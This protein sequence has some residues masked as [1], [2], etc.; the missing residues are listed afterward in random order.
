MKRITA[1]QR[2]AILELLERGVD[3][4]AIAQSLGV[5]KGQVAAVSAHLTM[6]TYGAAEITAARRRTRTAS[7]SSAEDERPKARSI[8]EA[9]AS[10][11]VLLGADVD[12]LEAR[13]WMPSPDEGT[14]NPHL[15]IVG[16]S[17]S[18]KTYAAQ[19][20]CAELVQQQIPAVIF[21]FGQGFSGTVV[22]EDFLRFAKALELNVGVDGVD[23]NPLQIFPS[24]IHGP[25]NVAQRIADTFAHVYPAIGVQQHAV[26]REAV[27]ET[28]R[29]AG[30]DQ[31]S[32][33]TWSE[34]APRLAQLRRSLERIASG[35]TSRGD[36]R[37]AATVLSHISTVFVF[38]VFRD[39][40][41]ELDWRKMFGAPA[42][43]YVLELKGLEQSLSRV[44]TEMLL[45]NLIGYVE[46]L[47][48][49]PLRCAILLDEAHRLSFEED[50]PVEKLLR[51][52]RK[53][54]LG[55][56]LASQQPED[57]S[58][59][60]FSNTAT[61]LVF[62]VSDDKGIVARQLARRSYEI[63]L[64]HLM[65]AVSS[66]RRGRA[67]LLGPKPPCIVDIEAFESRRARWDRV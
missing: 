15:L 47:G 4:D 33:A 56:I 42:G 61:K 51:E 39:T 64:S 12:T 36:N 49:S 18:G 46:S 22:P 65:K 1:E 57:F 17:G 9:P 19:C 38:D 44:V 11:R 28:F 23:I 45:W 16:E 59:V 5:T 62:N 34:P 30:I 27:L 41:R 52:G 2:R 6:K 25:V 8:T 40:G 58:S 67:C 37:Y 60:A 10:V 7:A 55:M 20:I 66:L 43:A 35:K 54:G 21:D 3:R 48:P 63:G 31:Q 50:S 29:S 24:D 53:F 14:P 32:K 26:L 13:Y